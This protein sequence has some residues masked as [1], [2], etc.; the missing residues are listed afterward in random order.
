[1]EKKGIITEAEGNLI[2]KV[3]NQTFK[4]FVASIVPVP[5]EEQVIFH[6]QSTPFV[7]ELP[8]YEKNEQP[9]V[10]ALVSINHA[11]G[12]GGF[13]SKM[14]EGSVIYL[15]MFQRDDLSKSCNGALSSIIEKIT[16]NTGYEYSVMFIS[17][18]NA[19]HLLMGEAKN[20]ESD[21]I[22]D[23]L[24]CLPPQ[25]NAV[26]CYGFGEMCPTGERSDG[27][28]KNRFHNI[29]FAVCAI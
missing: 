24:S 5:D 8:D 27:R 29:S 3:G 19:R 9:V 13:L 17:T 2:Q 28:A 14:P 12:A 26:G 22:S 16:E 6:F 15:N 20:L 23:K 25:C 1:M 10:R 11:T 7:M 4:E 21:I 18:C